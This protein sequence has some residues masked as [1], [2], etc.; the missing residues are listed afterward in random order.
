MEFARG[1]TRRGDT[2]PLSTCSGGRAPVVRGSATEK[3]KPF[4]GVSP[5]LVSAG[6]TP[7]SRHRGEAWVRVGAG[8]E[9]AVGRVQAAAE[10]WWAEWERRVAAVGLGRW[11]EEAAVDGGAGAG[12][13]G[14]L[15]RLLA[16]RPGFVL[17]RRFFT[18]GL[19]RRSGL[20]LG[21]AA[22][23]SI[24]GRPMSA[25]S[26]GGLGDS[27]SPGSSCSASRPTASTRAPLPSGTQRTR[28]APISGQGPGRADLSPTRTRAAARCRAA[29]RRPSRR[30][31]A[32]R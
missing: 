31:C 24:W 16:C 7:S 27:S 21:A 22:L 25:P 9:E 4:G 17:G 2:P 29:G 11:E 13:A 10:D 28:I 12:G 26:G 30:G 19:L 23:T 15:D 5:L 20:G 1:V 6:R 18:L 14:P 32:S 3:Y 8:V